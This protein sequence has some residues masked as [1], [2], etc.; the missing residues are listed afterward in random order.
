MTGVQ[1]CALPILVAD[2]KLEEH[3]FYIYLKNIGQR[4]ATKIKYSINYKNGDKSG[5]IEYI[6]AGQ[7]FKITLC[8]DPLSRDKN[9]AKS[10]NSE[11]MRKV[12]INRYNDIVIPK[13]YGYNITL[14]YNDIKDTI[15]DLILIDSENI[16]AKDYGVPILENKTYAI[17]FNNDNLQK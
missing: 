13:E 4:N 6:G 1:T 16:Y 8:Q 12:G 10:G 11:A 3:I 2:A 14:E 9:K 7:E 17:N 15:K 5:V